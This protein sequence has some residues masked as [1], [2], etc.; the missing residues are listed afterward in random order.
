LPLAEIDNETKNT[1]IRKIW[2]IT[3]SL[4]SAA[5]RGRRERRERQRIRK[6]QMLSKREATIH[7]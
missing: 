2:K 1:A 4:E 5:S 6:S 3:K 7:G